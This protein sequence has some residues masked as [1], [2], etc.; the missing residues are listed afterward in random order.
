[1]Y[2]AIQ[3]ARSFLIIWVHDQLSYPQLF[4][5]KAVWHSV[6]ATMDVVEHIRSLAN[7][8]GSLSPPEMRAVGRCAEIGKE[9]LKASFQ[10]M[11]KDAAGSAILNCKSADRTPRAQTKLPSG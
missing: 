9:V 6:A 4:L 7:A 5:L 2:A 3:F 8:S 11:V 10:K 1:M